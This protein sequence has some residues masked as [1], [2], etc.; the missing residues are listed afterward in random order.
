MLC[1]VAVGAG[2]RRRELKLLQWRD[3]DL[4]DFQSVVRSL[5]GPLVEPQSALERFFDVDLD[6]DVDL[7]DLA[8]WLNAFTGD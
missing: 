7:H 8:V 5:H 4:T 2:L 6:N 1:R 3:V